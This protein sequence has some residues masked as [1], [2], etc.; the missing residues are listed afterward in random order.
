M[1]GA[2][3]RLAEKDNLKK[4]PFR[5]LLESSPGSRVKSAQ[6]YSAPEELI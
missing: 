1:V 5:Q 2:R 4:N 6:I 3:N